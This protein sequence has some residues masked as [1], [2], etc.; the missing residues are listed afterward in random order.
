MV[1]LEAC[2][3]VGTQRLFYTLWETVYWIITIFI[4]LEEKNGLLLLFTLKFHVLLY[5]IDTYWWNSTLHLLFSFTNKKKSKLKQKPQ[6][7]S[8]LYAQILQGN[9]SKTFLIVFFYLLMHVYSHVL[10]WLEEYNNESSW[11]GL[12]GDSDAEI[13]QCSW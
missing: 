13:W 6:S 9:W 8:H 4:Y 7:C 11:R 10:M 3:D 12:G 2:N 1:W 5:V